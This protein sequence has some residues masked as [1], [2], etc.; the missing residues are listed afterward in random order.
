MTYRYQDNGSHLATNDR[1][2]LTNDAP[3]VPFY[4]K[5]G[6]KIYFWV[7]KMDKNFRNFQSF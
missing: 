5:M 6:K 4:P 3:N 7:I 1:D 2:H